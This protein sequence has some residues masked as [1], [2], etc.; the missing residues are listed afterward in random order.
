[1]RLS[2]VNALLFAG[3]AAVNLY[4]IAVP[5]YPLGVYWWQTHARHQQAKLAAQVKTIKSGTPAAAALGERLIIPSIVVNFSVLEDQSF[6]TVDKGIW[7]YPQSAVPGQTGNTVLIGHRFTYHGGSALTHLDLV[8][9]GDAITL[10]WS[11]QKFNYTVADIKIVSPNDISIIQPTTD[12][13]LTIYT[14]TPMWT[15]K[16]RLAVIAQENKS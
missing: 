12:K 9:L 11:G 2:R 10:V 3:I 8:K 16:M 4:V 1:M 13:R 7:H 14:C 6:H 5:L 15:N